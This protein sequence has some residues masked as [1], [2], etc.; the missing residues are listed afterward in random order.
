MDPI[1]IVRA[2][3][4]T[5]RPA[6]GNHVNLE[7]IPEALQKELGK[8]LEAMIADIDQRKAAAAD[9]AAS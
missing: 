8:S 6:A 3:I 4:L 7:H 9:P 1:P 5:P 2:E